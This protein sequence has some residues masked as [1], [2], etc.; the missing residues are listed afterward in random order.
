MKENIENFLK[1]FFQ[2]HFYGQHPEA[3]LRYAPIVK[4]I[5]KL[6]LGNSKILEIGSGSLGITPYL[7]RQIDAI[8]IDFSGPRTNLINKIKAKGVKLPFKKNSYDVTISADVL[9]HIEKENREKAIF[10]MLRI[11]KKLAVIVVPCGDYS[12]KQ[13]KDL[14][15]HW[16]KIFPN[17]NQFLEEHARNGLPQAEELLVIIDKC[18]RS[19]GK[20]AKVRS[21]ANL[22]LSIRN[23]LMRT[24]ITKNKYMYYLYLK[25]Y[26][27]FVPIL[28]YFNFGKT[29]RRVFV[30]EFSK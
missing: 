21:Y 14:R 19:L 16:N 8:D 7:K 1:N 27:L 15:D 22:N 30:I 10:E 26:L 12:Q 5:K 13:D 2:K 4:E 18:K 3:A 25:G 28:K 9:E 24:W 11:T 20:K 6:K 17:K 29:Y 23:V